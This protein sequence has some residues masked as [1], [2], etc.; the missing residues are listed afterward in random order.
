QGRAF[1]AVRD[2]RGADFEALAA[3]SGGA[4]AFLLDANAPGQFGGTGQ[5]ADW[6]AARPLA[7]RWPL[8]LAG[9]LTPAN[10][11]EAIRAVGP[12]GVDVASGVEAAPGKKDPAR[13]RA[14]VAAVREA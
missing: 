14:F 6:E 11:A 8:F 10:V 12:W 9:G 7:A 2:P 5:T 3:F 4:P 1:V 13:M